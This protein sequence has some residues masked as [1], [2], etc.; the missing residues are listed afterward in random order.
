M[1]KIGP[2]IWCGIGI[3]LMHVVTNEAFSQVRRVVGQVTSAG[4]PIPGVS[5]KLRGKGREAV[6]NEQGRYAIRAGARDVLV[7]SAVGYETNEVTVG[8]R[9]QI[10]V[11]LEEKVDELDEVVVVGYGTQKKSDVTN[12]VSSV[13]F[14]DLQNIPQSNTMN[15]LSGRVAGMSV[16]QAS[17][18]PGDDDNDVTVR[19]TGTLNDASPLVIIDGI[20]AEMQDLSTLSPQEIANVTVLKDASSTA[21]YGARGANGVILVTTKTPKEGRFRVSLNSYFGIQDATEKPKFVNSWQWMTLHNEASGRQL[22][23]QW[24]I[25]DVRS[26]I[27]TDTFSNYDPTDDVFRR[28]PQ[29]NYNLILSGGSKAIRFQGSFG[30]LNQEGILNGTSSDRFNYR[31]NIVVDITKKLQMGLNISGNTQDNHEN[32]GGIRGIMTNL[33]RNN[34]TIPAQYSTG[35]WGVYSLDNGARQMPALLYAQIGRTDRKTRKNNIVYFAQYKPVKGLTL[36]SQV[37][38]MNFDR[39]Q[40]RFNPTYSYDAPDGTPAQAN[41]VNT[42]INN[43]D[44]RNQFQVTTTANY[45]HTFN[46]I[47]R[48]TLLAGHEYIDFK[49]NTVQARGSNLPTNDQQQLARATT[50]ISINGTESAWRLQSFFGRINYALKGRYFLEA[51]LR[52]D[53]SSRFPDSKQYVYLPSVSAGW[54]ISNEPFFR[55]LN[56]D[57]VVDQ[58]K[59]RGGWGR[60]GND[61]MAPGR[62]QLGNYTHQQTLNLENYY[63]FGDQ[64][65]PG[66]AI[67]A[68]ANGDISWESTETTG[69]GVELSMF[70]KSLDITF[71]LYKRITDGI[72][73]RV[74]M[75]LSFGDATPAIQNVAEVSNKGWEVNANYHR[76]WN[77]FSFQISGNFSYNENEILSLRGEETVSGVYILREGVPFNSFYG[78][79]YDGIFQDAADIAN[80]PTLTPNPQVGMMKFKD[81]NEDGR[82]DDKDRTVLS[83]GNIPYSFGLAGGV[84]YKGF[85]LSFL[86]QGVQGKDI[87][88]RDWGNRPGNAGQTNFWREWWDNRYN[89]VNNPEGTWPVMS[90]S[91][92]GAN[93]TSTFWIHDASYVRL[94]NIE[95]GYGLPQKL[96]AKARISTARIFVGGQNLLT[97]TPLIKQIDPERRADLTSN[98]VFPQVK[99]ITA[100]FNFTF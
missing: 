73:F 76:A 84:A 43:G 98:A 24:A 36:K 55:N 27:L 40:E 91:S 77:E 14:E 18:Q 41:L 44:E 7:F 1:K 59:I 99:V 87:F 94:K 37:G 75:P 45:Q 22:Y 96:L 60:A 20:A 100:G 35:G 67:T 32:Y 65:Y 2:I 53:G 61:R 46:K 13:D 86:F 5:V 21:I 50:D 97:F 15:M 93:E 82:I 58:L 39:T 33:Y 81:L 12:A 83:S 11:F 9:K 80:S 71:D 54:M 95:L 48:L 69:A 74:P 10:D 25:D 90:R 79:V 62:G 49:Q 8:P 6:T 66:A 92:P 38:F 85:S 29:Q 4:T 56:V 26:G 30:Y 78:L 3:L 31:S 47:H 63:Y 57:G 23:P 64:L 34:P 51:N 72:L 70:K 52:T 28:A 42:L 16:V 89:A 68:F 88:V 19:G 17:G